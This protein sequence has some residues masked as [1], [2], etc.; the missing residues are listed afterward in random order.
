M[1]E[2]LA[3][4]ALISKCCREVANLEG[5]AAEIGVYE[6]DSAVL[7]KSELP[8]CTL[9]LFDTF[10]GMPKSMISEGDYHRECD[11]KTTSVEKVKK[12]LT[13]K[14]EIHAGVFPDTAAGLKPKLKFVHVDC[15]LYLSTKA[16]LTWAWENL[17]PGG[18]II[19]DD[20][21]FLPNA[22]R[23]VTEF[24][25]ATT[26]ATMEYFNGRVAIRGSGNA[27]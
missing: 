21:G 4:H 8:D 12:R 13:G 7:I 27:D 22:K 24:M 20:Y 23:A 18:V 2:Q 5:D 19:D 1:H 25:E 9:H 17:V 26:D 15:D 16:A 3:C 10:N 14:Y 6:G 11:F